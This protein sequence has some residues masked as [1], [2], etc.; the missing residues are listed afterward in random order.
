MPSRRW[1]HAAGVVVAAVVVAGCDVTADDEGP[2]ADEG[3]G[4]DQ[5]Q[6]A[7]AD[8]TIVLT[9][10][11]DLQWDQDAVTAEAGVIEVVLTCE[12]RVD[13]NLTI[14]ETGVEV[15]ACAPGAT[16][17]GAVEL[18]PGDYTFVCTVPGH[19]AT[20]RGTLTVEG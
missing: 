12:D 6:L 5:P 11:D 1:R 2:P 8:S 13:H 3:A 20:M 19:E 9:G 14:D 15:V 16:E 18:A 4:S 17:R 7:D 10:R